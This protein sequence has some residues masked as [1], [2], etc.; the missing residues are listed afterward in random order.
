MY[1][2]EYW[3]T[4]NMHIV[5]YL[6]I[7]NFYVLASQNKVLPNRL[8]ACSNPSDYELEMKLLLEQK[9]HKLVTIREL[10]PN[11]NKSKR[12]IRI[13]MEPICPG[14]NEIRFSTQTYPFGYLQVNCQKSPHV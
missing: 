6:L 14:I 3:M 10:L 11:S 12:S 1:Y 13:I 2:L 8:N 4:T 9:K 5:F 7:G